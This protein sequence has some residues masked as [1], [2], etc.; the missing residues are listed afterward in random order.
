MA[1][2]MTAMGW[3]E[4]LKL[5]DLEK[6][7]DAV[8]EEVAE[9]LKKQG[10]SSPMK[11]AGVEVSDLKGAVGFPKG[12][13]TAAFLKRAVL[14]AGHVQQAAAQTAARKIMEDDA[15][16]QTT[17]PQ[18]SSSSL[19]GGP[20]ALDVL[21][22]GASAAA[23]AA[24]LAEAS[25]NPREILDRGGFKDVPYHMVPDIT[26]FQ[27]LEAER[28]HAIR[29]RRQPFTYID[30]TCKEVLPMWLSQDMV[31]GRLALAGDQEVVDPTALSSTV[32]ALGAALRSATAAPR[33][34]RTWHQWTAAWLRYMPA[35][36]SCGH[37][38]LTTAIAYQAML[39]KLA[40]E[41]RTTDGS[42]YLAILYDEMVRRSWAQRVHGGDTVDWDK[43]V[44]KPDKAILDAA[45]SR[46][47]Q[48]L[49]SANLSKGK[50]R[51]QHPAQ[52]TQIVP[53]NHWQQSLESA[54][55]KATASA[56]AMAKN[57]DRSARELARQQQALAQRTQVLQD[58]AK[59]GGKKGGGKKG[60]GKKGNAN[61]ANQQDWW[62][63][64]W[65]KPGSAKRQ[66]KRDGW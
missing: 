22:P 34:F 41:Q 15:P 1:A 45:S 28:K 3:S 39:N 8:L 33:F 47:S 48:V 57:A 40:E 65:G 37:L 42:V 66:K 30:F 36:V 50:G 31:G 19:Y 23:V 25:V 13:A 35:A 64:A 7:D 29:D 61:Q 21:G 62:G 38:S 55:A 52:E 4:F 6:P 44:I 16:K 53:A 14:L 49:A 54:A 10:F 2:S 24:A 11:A 12:A 18:A 43:E 17:G 27:A 5:V 46:L 60:G 58:S 20:Q 59:G 26:L 9:F 56:Q 63:G 51:G 32:A